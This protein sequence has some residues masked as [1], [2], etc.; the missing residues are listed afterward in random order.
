MCGRDYGHVG[1]GS[2]RWNLVFEVLSSAP[3]RQLLYSLSKA[4][5]GEGVAVPLDHES[6]D[7]TDSVRRQEV[8]FRHVHLPKL[9]D[10]GYVRWESDPL[11]A[12]RGR[13]FQE[14]KA[15]GGAIVD[16]A[17]DLPAPLCYGCGLS[18]EE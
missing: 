16:A 17:E 4:P 6:T 1:D 5:V 8:E 14:I 2:G 11:W 7:R 10:A 12:Y 13:N 9:A 18:L 3:R 15:V